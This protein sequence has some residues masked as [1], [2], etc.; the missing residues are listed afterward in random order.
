M[1]GARA[2]LSA[3]VITR[4]NE[5]TI[6]RCMESLAFADEIIVLDSGSAD[7]TLEICRTLG[8]QVRQATDWPGYGPQKNRALD[9]AT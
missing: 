7:G 3:V 5:A 4:D 9:L 1:S 8:A 6:R 2:G